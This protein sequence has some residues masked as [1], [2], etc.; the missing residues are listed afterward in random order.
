MG[1]SARDSVPRI[2]SSGERREVIGFLGPREASF[3]RAAS[4]KHGQDGRG[5]KR[6]PKE[7]WTVSSLVVACSRALCTLWL[8]SGVVRIWCEAVLCLKF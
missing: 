7:L 3:S 5:V 6:P 8:A 1:V 4:E 2:N